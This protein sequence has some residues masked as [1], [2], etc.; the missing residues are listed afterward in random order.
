[1]GYLTLGRR[2]LNNVHDII[3]DRIDV[4][5]RGMLGLTVTCARCHDHKYDP[6]PTKDYYSLYGVFASTREPRDLPLI[7][8]PQQTKEFAAFEAEVAKREAE[9]QTEI[10]KR[11]AAHLKKLRD[12]FTVSEY[13]RAVLDLRNTREEEI[14]GA[15]RQRD[16]NRFVYDR[17]F[18][19]L[20]AEWKGKS[21]VYAP[22]LALAAISE[23][24]F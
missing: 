16:L 20:Q 24:D 11:H 17:W 8:E 21:P 5:A 22:L 4:V 15:L 18:G 3:D 6:I 14:R 19:F 1:M 2:F 7:G 9:I 13:V 12:W 10:S 23:K